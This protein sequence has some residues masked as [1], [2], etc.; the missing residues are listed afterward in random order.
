MHASNFLVACLAPVLALGLPNNAADK[1][2]LPPCD[3]QYRACRCPA[4][5]TFKNLTSFGIIGAPAIEVQ[6]IMG[7]FL[8]IR[9]QGGLIPASTTGTEGV[10]G[11]TRTFNFSAPAG[12]YYQITEV[13][14][15][16]KTYPDG[17]FIA[18]N[19]QD[20]RINPVVAIPG[21]GTY[22]GQWSQIIGEQTLI[23]NETAVAW[24]N[25]RCEI[26]ETF[27]A[28]QSHENGIRNASAV[29]AAAGKHTGVDVAPFTIFYTIRQD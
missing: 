21:G 6:N 14:D 9:Y 7:K 16:Y 8:D 10:V 5:S 19:E 25:W 29:I 4:G 17:S 23:A 15:K 3:A 12:G 18:N 28:A 11:A 1:K 13:L 24:R 26:G 22:K 2:K 27:P 20:Q